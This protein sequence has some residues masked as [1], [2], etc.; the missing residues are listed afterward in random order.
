MPRHPMHTVPQL[1]RNELSRGVFMHFTGWLAAATCDEPGKAI[2][3]ELVGAKHEH[4]VSIMNGLSVNLRLPILIL[5][6]VMTQLTQIPFYFS[7]L[8]MAFYRPDKKRY[9]MVVDGH[10]FPSDR[11]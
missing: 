3:A 1:R 9:K 10:A 4:E 7:L 2:T 8:L 5:K 6:S 11:V